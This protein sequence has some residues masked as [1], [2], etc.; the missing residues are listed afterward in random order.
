MAIAIGEVV[1]TACVSHKFDNPRTVLRM[2]V[3]SR[4][5]QR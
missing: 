3:V 4:Y 5:G 1:M 2:S